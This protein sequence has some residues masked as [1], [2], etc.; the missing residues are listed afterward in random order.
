VRPAPPQEG[1]PRVR[2]GP[3]LTRPPLSA[4]RFAAGLA[5]LTL[6][7]LALLLPNL[8]LAPLERAEIY[9]LDAARGM[10]ESG[11]WVVPRYEGQPFFDKPVL[12]YWLMA[13]AMEGLGTAAGAARLV[14]VL[15]SIGVMLA[16]AWLGTL[17]FDRR[18]GLAGG[19]VLATTLAFLSFARVAMSDMLLALWT[20]LAVAL[21]VLAYRPGAPAWTVPL[22]GAVAG[23]GFATKGPIALLV[24]GLAILLLLWENRRRPLHPGLTGPAWVPCGAGPIA[25]A[26]LAFALLGL[27]WF[28]FVYMRLGG[29]PLVFFFFR[30]NVERFAGEAYDVGRPLWFYPPAYFAEGLP[31]SPFL[32]IALWR[33]LRS[34]EGEEKARTRFLALWVALVLVPLSL[35][36]GKIDYYLLPV[37]PAISLVIGRYLT[38]V[39]WKK[40]DRWWASAALLIEAAAVVLLLVRPPQVPGEWLPGPVARA[41]LLTLLAAGALVLLA[42]AARPVAA[43]VTAALASLIA[44]AWLV[45]VVFYLP[46]FASAQPNRA[47]VADVARE[48]QYRPDLRMAFCSDPTRVRRD[49]L[50]HVRLAARSECDLWSLAGSREPF[51][52]LATPAQDAS[53]RVDPRYREIARY[54]Y[55]PAS[56]LTL[57]GLFSLREPGEIV[58][59]ANFATSDPVAE[60]KRKREYRKAIQ[61]ARRQGRFKKKRK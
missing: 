8:G 35:S 37:Y 23:L 50:L 20:T 28:V 39:P 31:W 7:L 49:V 4:S 14:P 29:E 1:R 33:L 10:V 48:R 45:L 5:L 56:A 34:R 41:L 57:G 58:L 21:A 24:P 16:T 19:L 17:L 43:R 12:A 13:A 42:V 51:L 44:A 55:V 40:A 18:S 25:L 9:F 38:A 27:S 53:F 52:L 47:I 60:R 3:P 26:A 59:G 2:P 54:R 46:A 15:A 61:E 32:P 36:R 11:D 30:E 22:L 6:G